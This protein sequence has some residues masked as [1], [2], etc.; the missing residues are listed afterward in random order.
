VPTDLGSF[1]GD[2]AALFRPAVE[3]RQISFN[4][5]IQPHEASVFIDPLF[6][7][8]VVTNLLSNALKYTENGQITVKLTY[9]T[10]ANIDVT[11]TGC[12]IPTSELGEVTDRYHRATTALAR[13]I[14][15]TG[16]GL[17][18]A[19][20]ILRL[21]G[22]DLYIYSQTA[23]E[24]GESHGSTF[25]ARIPLVQRAL[26]V[27][28]PERGSLGA[29]GKAIVA[30]AMHWNTNELLTPVSETCSDSQR[31]G[32]P[33]EALLFN[34]TDVLLLVE[35][36]QD[37]R[38]YIKGIFAPYCNVVE[39]ANGE[40]A[41][42][43]AR[44]HP[45]NLIL[46]DMMMPKLNG[47]GL[48]AEIR[49]DPR[50]RLVPMLLLSA[51]SDDD[52]RIS[53]LTTGAEDFILKPFRP[54]ELLA[55]VHL[56]MQV[57]KRLI[58]LEALY[59]QRQKEIALLS[60]YCP[61]GIVRADAA[62]QLLYCNDAWRACAGMSGRDDPTMWTQRVDE[63]TLRQLTL[64]W[65]RFIHGDQR[66]T[67]MTWKWISGST[68]SGT[69]IRLDKVDPAMSGIL[70]C[71]SDISYQE[72]RMREAE[73]RRIEAEESKRQH[74]LLVDVTSHEIRTPVSAILHCSS[75]VR[76][77][78]AELKETFRNG[79]KPSEQALR[80]L[81]EDLEALDSESFDDELC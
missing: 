25:R 26:N 1:V 16:I 4:V 68:V 35:D 76:E 47:Q 69:F 3:R 48:L 41:L 64:G 38:S 54:K 46:S 81:D 59:A 74:E 10:H 7:E 62:G 77:N 8:T 29:Y 12:G 49:K 2:F 32:V 13:G 50:T 57:G 66:E 61:S 30:E 51:A 67:Q 70:G 20:E 27:N 43:I 24:A 22:G 21:H 42:A 75:F 33:S 79:S 44:A 37:M 58:S 36:N 19:K 60:D 53:A 71:V 80:R 34:P 56:H 15:G 5:E 55:R 39:A 45:P 11:D 6:L 78:L 73:R 65:E 52:L 17:A 63:Q 18:L 9:D 72:E 40:T 23:E 31:S 14:E 28:G